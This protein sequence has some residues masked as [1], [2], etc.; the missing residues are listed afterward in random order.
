MLLCV[1]VE[2][3]S[4]KGTSI[5]THKNEAKVSCFHRRSACPEEDAPL[6]E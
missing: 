5:T 4:Q 1:D 6:I 2:G 3:K